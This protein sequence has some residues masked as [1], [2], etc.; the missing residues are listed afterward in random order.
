[1]RPLPLSVGPVDLWELASTSL[2]ERYSCPYQGSGPWDVI[3]PRF[4]WEERSHDEHLGL[5]E[6]C[7]RSAARPY[8]QPA[9]RAR[10]FYLDLATNHLLLFSFASRGVQR[11][12]KLRHAAF[13]DSLIC[14]DSDVLRSG[15]PLVLTLNDRLPSHEGQ[16]EKHTFIPLHDFILWLRY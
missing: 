4:R 14:L 6:K 5:N 3:S 1:M 7:S 8:K 2:K 9:Y 16:S 12:A 10:Y 15:E 13:P 11:W